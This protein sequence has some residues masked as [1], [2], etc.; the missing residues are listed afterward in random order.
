MI[1]SIIKVM[2]HSFQWKISFKN[3]FSCFLV[4]GNIYIYIYKVPRKLFLVNL[5][6][7][8][9]FL[10]LFSTHLRFEEKKNN[11]SVG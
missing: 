8:T 10:R 1:S 6:S 7:I 2:L 9:Y 5:K 3:G 4:S 11:E